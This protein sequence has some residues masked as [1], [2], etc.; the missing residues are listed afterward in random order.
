M[1]CFTLLS[2]VLIPIVISQED[3]VF[4]NVDEGDINTRVEGDSVSEDDVNTRFINFGTFDL[5]AAAGAVGA[6]ALG[7]IVGN[8]ATNLAGNFLNNC[9]N[10]GKRSILMHKLEKRQAIEANERTG[11]PNADPEVAERFLPCPQDIFNP[12]GSQ[13]SGRYCDRCYCSRDYDCRRD[14]RKCGNGYNSNYGYKPNN[15]NNNYGQNTGWSSNSGSNNYGNNNNGA[16]SHG[17]HVNCNT[18]RCSN[19]SCKNDCLKCLNSN[20]NYYNSGNTGWSNS[21][22]GSYNNGWR[23]SVSGRTGGDEEVGE[24]GEEFSKE[25]NN[26]ETVV[27]A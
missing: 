27:F 13:N 23:S 21:N 1:K 9:N 7:T 8:T 26:E 14:C 2:V 10:R 18:C 6:A 3:V 25:N 22:G 15:G 4:K 20:N 12:G 16:H 17:N 19:Y 5:N 24:G 11:N